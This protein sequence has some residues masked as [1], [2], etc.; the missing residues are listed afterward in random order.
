[1][2]AD[3]SAV[4]YARNLTWFVLLL[5]I[6]TLAGLKFTPPL[7]NEAELLDA[8][9]S[10]LAPMSVPYSLDATS[11]GI[12][13]SPIDIDVNEVI[14]EVDDTFTAIARVSLFPVFTAPTYRKSYETSVGGVPALK[15]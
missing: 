5:R 8:N 4:G 9:T 7:K 11:F 3:K 2:L 15:L 10:V 14:A 12:I 13:M 6:T 1:M